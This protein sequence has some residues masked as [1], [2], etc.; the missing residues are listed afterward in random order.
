MTEAGPIQGFKKQSAKEDLAI[1]CFLGIPYAAPPVGALRWKSP[2]P[3]ESWNET[4]SCF[5]FSADFPQATNPLFRALHQS[6]DCLYLN[7]WAPAFKDGKKLPVMV[8]IHGGGF[9]GGSGSDQRSDGALMAAKGV[10]VVSFNYRSGVFGFLAHPELSAES[11]LKVSGNYGLQDQIAALKWIQ[12]NIDQFNGDPNKVTVFGVSAGS[13]SISLLLTCPQAKGLFQQ[14]ILHS[15]GAARPLA[16]LAQA[17]ALSLKELGADIERLRSLSA[18]DIFKLTSLLNPKI[19]GL[20]TPR[21]LRPILDGVYLSENERDVFKDHRQMM[22]PMIVGSNLD[23]GSLLTK[24]WAIK[25]LDDFAGLVSSNFNALSSD[26]LALYPVRAEEEIRIRVAELFGDTQFNYGTRLLAQSNSNQVANT[27][28]YLFAKR[29][30]SQIDGPHHGQEVAHVFGN[31][32]AKVTPV[33]NDYDHRDEVIS[34]AL[35]NYWVQLAYTGNPNQAELP[36]WIRYELGSDNMIVFENEIS[37]ANEFRKN[38]LDFI[39][40]YFQSNSCL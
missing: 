12:K 26:A 2:Q 19:R 21:I 15:P 32:F 9:V 24:D 4:R 31:L 13:A 36:E 33:E 1:D 28:R 17:E 40:Q 6:E 29:R 22:L 35:L 39:D 34:N 37:K 14:S 3:L 23:E 8:W 10:V 38:N 7:V 25:S 16:T 11:E 30:P 5:D 20:T 27:W 18:Q